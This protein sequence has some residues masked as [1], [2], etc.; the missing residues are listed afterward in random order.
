LTEA[1]E[2]RTGLSDRVTDRTLYVLFVYC[3]EEGEHVGWSV[4]AVPDRLQ[5]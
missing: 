4:A 2:T 5:A 3:L 1:G